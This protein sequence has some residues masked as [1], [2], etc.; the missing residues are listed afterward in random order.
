M[1]QACDENTQV[2]EYTSILTPQLRGQSKAQLMSRSQVRVLQESL[3]LIVFLLAFFYFKLRFCNDLIIPQKHS[4]CE[5]AMFQHQQRL[6][7]LPLQ[8]SWQSTGFVL[9]GSLVRIRQEA[10]TPQ[11]EKAKA[12]HSFEGWLI[13]GGMVKQVDTSD[14]SPGAYKSVRVRVPLPLRVILFFHQLQHVVF[15]HLFLIRSVKIV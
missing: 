8:L 15:F 6:V 11:M 7:Y 12:R 14:L 4:C 5:T 10:L 2:C 1:S 3:W 13:I 9:P